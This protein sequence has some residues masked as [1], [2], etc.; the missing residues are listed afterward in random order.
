MQTTKETQQEKLDEHINIGEME[1]GNEDMP[2]L[3]PKD[4][5]VIA[6][7]S[8]IVEGHGRIISFKCNHPNKEKPLSFSRVK[9]ETQNKI[10]IS[11]MWVR[12]DSKGN[13]QKNSTLGK[14]LRYYGAK[15]PIDMVGK[16]IHTT[17]DVNGYLCIKAY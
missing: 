11:G 6:Y 17:G 16:T 4:C 10:G 14:C 5:V 1:V 15:K 12:Q 8:K 9:Y 3:E 13:I 2:R 7:E